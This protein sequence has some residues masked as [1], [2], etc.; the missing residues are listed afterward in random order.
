M[1][2]YCVVLQVAQKSVPAPSRLPVTAL[3]E[4]CQVEG[5]GRFSAFSSGRVRVVYVDRTSLDMSADLRARIRNKD[6]QE[7]VSVIHA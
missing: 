3:L 1:Y 4:E 5:V 6:Q 7:V 2:C